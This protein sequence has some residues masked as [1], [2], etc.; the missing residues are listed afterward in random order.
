MT[1]KMIEKTELT[2]GDLPVYYN[3]RF[4]DIH[5][6]ME[7]NFSFSTHGT[8]YIARNDKY[9]ATSKIKDIVAKIYNFAFKNTNNLG[10]NF[11]LHQS[12]NNN[13]SLTLQYSTDGIKQYNYQNDKLKSHKFKNSVLERW[14]VHGQYTENFKRNSFEVNNNDLVLVK[15]MT[16]DIPIYILIDRNQCLGEILKTINKSFKKYKN[17]YDENN[18]LLNT[19]TKI[20]L[21]KNPTNILTLK[22]EIPKITISEDKKKINLDEKNGSIY[23]LQEREHIRM[24]ESVYKIGKTTRSVEKR[25]SEYPKKSILYLSYGGIKLDKLNDVETQLISLLSDKYINR[26]DIGKEYFEGN[27]KD[28]IDLINVHMIKNIY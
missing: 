20:G 26:S 23:L 9:I 21:I 6:N 4:L 8:I 5:P 28:I 24:N 17:I 10:F 25:A 7:T 2:L 1:S 11:I 12:I 14:E 19:H 16:S 13:T 18:N 27:L 22:I 15:V 3:L